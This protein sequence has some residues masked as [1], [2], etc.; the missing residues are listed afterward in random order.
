MTLVWSD[1]GNV[2]QLAEPCK[3]WEL[4]L[5]G[6]SLFPPGGSISIQRKS[7][8]NMFKNATCMHTYIYTHTIPTHIHTCNAHIH[9]HIFHA[10]ARTW[11]EHSHMLCTLVHDTPVCHVY[12]CTHIHMCHAHVYTCH[13][14]TYTQFSSLLF[15]VHKE[16]REDPPV[17]IPFA[18]MMSHKWPLGAPDLFPASTQRCCDEE[19]LH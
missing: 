10:Q 17:D 13:V 1:S 6:A 18:R 9:I 16:P 4:W 11:Y 7:L 19:D 15:P 3:L 12:K 5:S 8:N 2:S 14:H